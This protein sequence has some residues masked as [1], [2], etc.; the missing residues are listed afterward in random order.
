MASNGASNGAEREILS[1]LDGQRE[2]MTALCSG[3]AISIPLDRGPSP[4]EG[5]GPCCAKGCHSGRSRKSLD[6]TQ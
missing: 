4:G 1:W 3:G 6:R 2:A 5:N